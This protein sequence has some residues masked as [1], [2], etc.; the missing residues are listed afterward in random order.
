MFVT[1]TK[2]TLPLFCRRESSYRF[3]LES[4]T[5]ESYAQIAWVLVFPH[6]VLQEV[7][8]THTHAVCGFGDSCGARLGADE[9][10]GGTPFGEG[11]DAG[12]G[13]VILPYHLLCGLYSQPE[14]SRGLAGQECSRRGKQHRK[15]ASSIG[16]VSG[17]A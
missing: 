13:G 12:V 14:V 6:V 4:E 5:S 17:L 11:L 16:D 10:R 9:T 8:F 1:P 2:P 3:V 7:Y 15:R